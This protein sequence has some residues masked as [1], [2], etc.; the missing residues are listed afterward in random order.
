VDAASFLNG[1]EG[2]HGARDYLED[3]LAF[4]YI[5]DKHG[6]S[7]LQNFIRDVIARKGDIKGALD[8]TLHE[9]WDEFQSNV[10]AYSEDQLFMVGRNLR[11]V[12]TEKAY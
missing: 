7:A 8:Y 1:L 6:V 3:Y 11:G 2:P 10:R 9:S 4:Q 12:T 5:H